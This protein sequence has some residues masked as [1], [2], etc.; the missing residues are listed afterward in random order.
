MKCEMYVRCRLRTTHAARDDA[1]QTNVRS[2]RES[3]KTK[4]AAVT[5]KPH[6]ALN[7]T[8]NHCIQLTTDGVLSDPRR[9][10]GVLHHPDVGG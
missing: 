6:R 5:Q 2:V 4:A 1:E 9:A 10:E 3:V 7:E 8:W